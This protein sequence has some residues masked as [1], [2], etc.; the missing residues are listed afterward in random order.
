MTWTP[1]NWLLPHQVAAARR[2]AGSLQC[3]GTAVLA[4]AV[5][6]GKTYT[7]LAVATRYLRITAVVPACIVPQWERTARRL[8]IAIVVRSHEGLSRGGTVPRSD[9]VIVDEA[10]R[11]RNDATKR[12]DA[13]AGGIGR[14]DVLLVSATPVV[15]HPRDLVRGLRLGLT[16]S[17]LSVF[18]VPSLEQE[19]E[20]SDFSALAHAVDR[21]TTARPVDVLEQTGSV[22][23]SVNEGSVAREASTEPDLLARLVGVVRALGFP[24]TTGATE[25]LLRLHLLHRLASSISAFRGTVTRHLAYVDRA[26]AT[27]GGCIPSRKRLR[28]V[29]GPGDDLQFELWGSGGPDGAMIPC[30]IAELAGERRVL[31]QLLDLLQADAPSPKAAC[32]REACSKARKTIVFTT[33][34]ETAF[35]LAARLN[36]NRVGVVAAGRGRIATGP[37]GIQRVLDLFAPVARGVQGGVHRRLSVDVLIATDLASEGLDLQDADAVVHYDL[38]WTPVRLAQR[39]GRT[40]RLGSTQRQVRVTWFAPPPTLERHLRI[41]RRL[42]RKA[43]LQMA[44]S[45]PATAVV[46]RSRLFNRAV[47]AKEWLGHDEPDGRHASSPRP[48]YAVVRGPAALVAAIRWDVRSAIIEDVVALEGSPP[49]LITNPWAAYRLLAR[50]RG[51]TV[52]EVAIEPDLLRGLMRVLRSRLRLAHAGDSGKATLSH[53]RRVLVRGVAAAKARDAAAITL[54]DRVLGCLQHGTRVG[55]ARRLGALLDSGTPHAA[56]AD[57]LRDVPMSGF[58]QPGVEVLAVLAGDG[59]IRP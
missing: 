29:F 25:H 9:L 31:L 13:L 32:L 21:L 37:A 8:G 3:F 20:A 34:A 19:A 2:V 11:F 18:G 57:W 12:Y 46:G 6:L 50:L 54:L 45:T 52:R 5:G 30:S 38:P 7:S 59:S 53:R 51:E 14:A 43:Q 41:E 22:L 56:V 44:L 4:D 47:S 33:S 17:A 10:H 26:L 39:I 1:P 35:E 28:E 15:N 36:W 24:G 55:A 16:D 42:S 23:P 48:A 49:R 40:V 27:D 58:D